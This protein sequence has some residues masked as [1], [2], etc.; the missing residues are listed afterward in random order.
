MD[1]ALGE[2]GGAILRI[3]AGFSIL[4][5]QPIRINNIR[6][7]RPK[8]GLRLQ[9]LLG[10]RTLSKLTSSELSECQVGTQNLTLNPKQSVNSNIDVNITTAAN[11]GLL[12]QPIQI[13]SLGFK[14]FEKIK[15]TINGGGTF[16]KWAPSLNYLKYVTYNIFGNHGFAVDIDIQK[17]GFYPKGGAVAICTINPPKN[18]LKSLNLTELGFIDL[19]QGEIICTNH[20]INKK[21]CERIKKTLI[22]NINKNLGTDVKINYKYVNSLSPGV[23]LSLWANSDTG[24]IISTGTILGERNITSEDL[25]RFAADKI[26]TYIKNKIPVDNYLSDQL[27]PFMGFIEAPSSIKVLE[28]TNHTKTNLELIKLF[29]QR[30]YQIKKEKTHFIIE[31]EKFENKTYK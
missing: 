29:L 21:I 14:K 23:G 10:L 25:G 5:K 2:G 31:L 15:I 30:D 22:L 1:G 9:H 12:L 24:A 8:P 7:N 4:F 16:G 13:A 28:V 27:I 17:H 18:E 3:A 19:I 11:I 6:A 20:L 26:S